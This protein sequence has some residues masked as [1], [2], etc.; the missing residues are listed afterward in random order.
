LNVY[1]RE[2]ESVLD[3][4]SGIA[5]S[6]VFGAPHPDFGEAVA[7]VVELE[8]GAGFDEAAAIAAAKT[9][10]AAYKVPKRILA[11]NEIPRNR[12]GKVLKA[13]LRANYRSLFVPVKT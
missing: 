3:T 13:E 1:P 5:Q 8:T 7:A 9:R 4:L 10:L 6:A 12:M 11:V 2:V